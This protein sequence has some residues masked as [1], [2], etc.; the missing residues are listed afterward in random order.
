MDK[1]LLKQWVENYRERDCLL[2]DGGFKSAHAIGRDTV[3]GDEYIDK[4]FQFLRKLA[5]L[6]L[7]T[8]KKQKTISKIV[9]SYSLKHKYER[10]TGYI[11]NGM[12]ILALTLAG[13]H[14]KPNTYSGTNTGFAC[15]AD[16]SLL[17]EQNPA[18][19]EAEKILFEMFTDSNP[20][21]SKT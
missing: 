8:L 16:Y 9:T 18:G 3:I 5:A 19:R 10:I 21:Y 11:C 15:K 12:M 1:E 7:L 14:C 6:C 4:H 2:T 17:F 13:F 20:Y